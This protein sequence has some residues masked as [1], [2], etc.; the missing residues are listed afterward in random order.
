M[1]GGVITRP[2]NTT[3]KVSL[4]IVITLGV[5]LVPGLIVAALG[6]G[7][8]A[9]LAGLAAFGAFLAVMQ[10]GLRAGIGFSVVAAV[11]A[12]LVAASASN[13][14]LSALVFF[15]CGLGV[16][17]SGR[18]GR[19]MAYVQVPIMAGFILGNV[20][21]FH[22]GLAGD[23]LILS[24]VILV[25]GLFSALVMAAVTKQLD[26][27]EPEHL[28]GPRSELYGV[29]LGVMLG[30]AAYCVS[31]FD[32]AHAGSW[33]I[34]TFVVVIQPRLNDSL[35][36]ALHRAAGTILGFF[37]SIGIATTIHNPVMLYIAGAVALLFALVDVIEHKPY[38]LFAT[39]ITVAVVIFEGSSTSILVTAQQRLWATAV[40]ASIATVVTA[41]LAAIVRRRN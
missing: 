6:F 17:F 41:V 26:R 22:E 10:V 23:A 9:G 7:S 18:R 5:T 34:L 11:V 28:S 12:G 29:V 39:A 25:A 4:F 36:K 16:G 27:H 32:L 20:P 3:A 40:A 33:V 24:G 30:G 19:R 1:D 15:G 31:A 2:T 35:M 38:W 8:A 37:I 13:P 21:N 14:W